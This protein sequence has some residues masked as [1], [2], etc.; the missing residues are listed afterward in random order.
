MVQ[1]LS[2][3]L[4][5]LRRLGAGTYLV[6]IALSLATIF[7]VLGFQATRLRELAREPRRSR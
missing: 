2:S 7:K 5:G 1:V 4:E 3:W 6:S